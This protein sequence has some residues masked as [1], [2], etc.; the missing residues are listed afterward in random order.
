MNILKYIREKKQAIK[1]YS[2]KR[3][4]E[5]DLRRQ[6]QMKELA[7]QKAMLKR[8][9]AYDKLKGEVREMKHPFLTGMAKNIGKNVQKA[10]KKTKK[11][12]SVGKKDKTPFGEHKTIWG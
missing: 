1:E 3:D 6:E 12:L 5:A 9:V 8:K 4:F 2:K 7:E 10:H 11:K